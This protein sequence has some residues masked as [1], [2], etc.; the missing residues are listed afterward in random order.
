[1]INGIPLIVLAIPCRDE[2]KTG[3]SECFSHMCFWS[4]RNIHAHFA[5]M[6]QRG[7]MI[8]GQRNDLV[9][10]ALKET[11]DWILWLDSD[12]VFP[13]D[14]IR[15][16]LSHQKPI[17]GATYNKRVA[18]FETLGHFVDT[19]QDT[20]SGG[21]RKANYLPG[22]CIMVSGDVYRALRYPWYFETYTW[23]ANSPLDAFLA[24]LDDI[25]YVKMPDSVRSAI[26]SAKGIR[27][28]LTEN[29]IP[30]S[31]KGRHT[32]SED[33]N[34]CRKAQRAGFEIF[35]D[36]DLTFQMGHIGEQVVTC[37]RPPANG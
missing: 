35:C 4:A 27:E 9:K 11:P 32:M 29:E 15:R 19:N 21:L 2:I 30:V 24:M 23:D 22:G 16:L 13:P 17:V 3:F 26:Y 31:I 25:S 8:S 5:V 7:A 34:F 10:R 6:S 28:W 18:P 37:E 36:L 14:T 20:A 33:Y 1:M 12:M